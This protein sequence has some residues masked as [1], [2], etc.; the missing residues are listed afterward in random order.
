MIFS[1]PFNIKV[2]SGDR[3]V[4][5]I[6]IN[7][8]IIHKIKEDSQGWKRFSSYEA[9]KPR[10]GKS[11]SFSS[12]NHIKEIEKKMSHK[13][14]DHVSW[15]RTH[16]WLFA[17][18]LL[19]RYI[20]IPRV[21]WLSTQS[22]RSMQSQRSEKSMQRTAWPHRPPKKG[23]S[24]M[25]CKQINTHTTEEVSQSTRKCDHASFRF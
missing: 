18:L 13:Y 25:S 6:L 9:R 23:T 24:T 16:R 11:A 1:A 21:H 14:L 4:S 12:M 3:R 17:K 20:T 22:T 19:Q 5:N 2:E 10:S 7:K 8:S 15:V